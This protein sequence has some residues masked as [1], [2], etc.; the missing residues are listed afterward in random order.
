MIQIELLENYPEH[1]S[2]LAE[3]WYD[4]LGKIW[5]SGVSPANVVNNLKTHLNT[6][7]L[8]LAYVALHNQNP[9]GMA[10][11]RVNDGI[12][13]DLSPWL[14]SL[15][16]DTHFQKQG[17]GNQLINTV[18]EKAKNMGFQQCYLFAL[19]PTIPEWYEKLGWKKIGMDQ[20]KEHP[21]TVMEVSL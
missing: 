18:K 13:P 16:V 2:R 4:V 8:P 17:I 10:S 14:G 3:I 15:V 19:D 11:L 6:E 20:F 21:V 12:R 5:I 1:I 9:V 7:T